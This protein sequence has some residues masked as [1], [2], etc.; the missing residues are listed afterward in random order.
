[1]N[2]SDKSKILCFGEILWDI[3]PESRS[4]GGAPMNVAVH[5]SRLGLDVRFVSR[6]GDD[7]MG[8]ELK[9]YLESVNFTDY[10][11]QLDPHHSTGTAQ[12]DMSDPNDPRYQFPDCAWDHMEWTRDLISLAESSD[13]IIHGSLIARKPSSYNTLTQLIRDAKKFKVFDVN[14]R[15]LHYSKGLIQELL[16][17]ADLVKMN[18][19][20]LQTIGGWF[21]EPADEA[22]LLRKIRDRFDCQVISVTHGK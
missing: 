21:V 5:L 9:R 7:S 2:L 18:Y 6:I 8:H 15:N 10:F 20:E 19:S 3:L 14:L 17:Q 4:P 22:T 13:I 1:M 11:L 16:K 12:V